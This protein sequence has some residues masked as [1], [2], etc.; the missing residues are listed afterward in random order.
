M[1]SVLTRSQ[2][3]FDSEFQIDISDRA[4]S[5]ESMGTISLLDTTAAMC[6]GGTINLFVLFS[7]DKMLLDQIYTKMTDDIA[8]DDDEIEF[9]RHATAKDVINTV[10][11]HCT[12]DWQSID[13][14]GVVLEPPIILDDI[15][16]VRRL[17]QS[18]FY[19]AHIQTLFGRM[20]VSLA[21]LPDLMQQLE[22]RT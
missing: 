8:I 19:T 14:L 9:Y 13:H 10:M 6:T 12:I 1:K 16:Q 20:I 5:E 21:G 17:Q 2:A 11:G 3:Y 7:F 22:E 18:V 15:K 4:H